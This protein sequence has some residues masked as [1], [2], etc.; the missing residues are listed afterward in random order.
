M[1]AGNLAICMR[2]NILS[3]AEEHTLPL[4]VLLEVTG[5][6][7]QLVE[8]LIEHHGEVFGE[9]VV[10]LAGALVEELPA[11]EAEAET[12]E[13]PPVTLGSTADS[14]IWPEHLKSS[15][16]EKRHLRLDTIAW[17]ILGYLRHP[18]GTGTYN[19]EIHII[20]DQQN[21]KPG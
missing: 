5:K 18:L 21:D 16:R 13:V 15:S 2:P 12:A 4:D 20:L 14:L 19:T 7:M 11:P 10:G 1:T 8:F 3:P 6:V 9:E 17:E